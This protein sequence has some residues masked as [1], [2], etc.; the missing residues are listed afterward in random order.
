MIPET[1]DRKL[2]CCAFTLFELIVVMVIIA[3]MVTVVAP[4]ATRSNEA[5][6][7]TQEC[8]S[9]AEAVNYI[10]DLAMDTKR[11]TRIL[12]DPE[13]N[14][15]MLEMATG[16]NNQDYEPIEA[17]GYAMRYFSRNIRI[18]DITGF[19]VE[20]NDH[21]LVF[22]PARPWPNASISLST[23]DEIKTITI[24][25]KRVEVEDSAI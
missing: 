9:L 7:I 10:A 17:L 22:E 19:G 6:K 11:P 16:I 8:L 23:S 5:L 12:I 3:A 25:G 15:Y 20:G 21:C 18:I 1:Y 14:S 13:N 2:R 24:R 4:Y